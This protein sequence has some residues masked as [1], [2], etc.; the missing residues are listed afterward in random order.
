M[1]KEI[2]M[3]TL[4]GV[5]VDFDKEIRLDGE[6]IVNGDLPRKFYE[7][8]SDVCD[9]ILNNIF[10][11][12]APNNH[13]VDCTIILNSSE[14][15]DINDCLSILFDKNVIDQEEFGKT[16]DKDSKSYIYLILPWI[17]LNDLKDGENITFSFK[18][19]KNLFLNLKVD[20]KTRIKKFI[21]SN[22]R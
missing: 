10:D 2:I 8:D 3:K 18:N 11:N 13:F 20:I 15:N 14:D 9:H 6:L 22:L 21:E 19:M 7:L 17:Y 16:F 1:K 4:K 5:N 12:V